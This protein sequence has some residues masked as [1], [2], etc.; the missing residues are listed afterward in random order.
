[1]TPA[2]DLSELI[3]TVRQD[4][5][6]VDDLDL[7]ATASATVAQLED[8]GDALL[9]HFVDRCR[10]SGRSWSEISAAL[11]VSKQAVHK[12]FS[13]S[14]PTF[15]RFTE[16]A[17]AVLKAAPGV[18]D[19]LGHETV[20]AEDL[21]VALYGAPGGIAAQVLVGL[22]LDRA[23]A[24]ERVLAVSPRG[25]GGAPDLVASWSPA[26]RQVLRRAVDEALGLAHNYVGTEHL[27]LALFADTKNLAGAA[28]A[29]GGVAPDEARALVLEALRGLQAAKGE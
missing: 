27:L 2:P 4:A 11:G 1:M 20:G 8:V 18:A 26:A 21:L 7:L 9:G 6:S 15:E 25:A 23:A 16:R 17:R 19:E 14:A 24:V 22:G 12:R 3:N 5:A 10:R 28:L 13:A 29:A